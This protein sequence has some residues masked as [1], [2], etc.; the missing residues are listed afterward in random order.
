MTKI[1]LSRAVTPDDIAAVRAVFEDY[2]AFIE[3]FL[4]QSLGF[5]GTE[6]EFAT[7][8]DIYDT[9]LI[10]KVDGA[11]VAACG[12]KPF[13]PGI[14]ELKR[15]YCRPEGRGHDLGRKLTSAAVMAARDMGYNHMYLDTDAGLTH[16]NRIYESMGFTDIDRYYDNPMGC[17]RYMAL[18]LS[19]T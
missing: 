11:P 19:Q 1:T 5:Q 2:M 15:L 16:A 10:A 7:F 4:G 17:S 3:G 18:D 13:K 12:I 6:K 9:L 14:C 8:P